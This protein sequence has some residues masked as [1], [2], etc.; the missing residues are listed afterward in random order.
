MEDYNTFW[1]RKILRAHFTRIDPSQ[2]DLHAPA[3]ICN[4][5]SSFEDW[6]A[7]ISQRLYDDSHTLAEV[8]HVEANRCCRDGSP[9]LKLV[10][11]IVKVIDGA[12]KQR[13]EGF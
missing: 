4:D 10:F 6:K 12:E 11:M 5:Y 3:A 1:N 8:N 7:I 9:R 2:R 13:V